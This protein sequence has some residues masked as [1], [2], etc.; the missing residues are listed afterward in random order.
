MK[1]AN[2]LLIITTLVLCALVAFSSCTG[3]GEETTA[4]PDP[5]ENTSA[6]APE[7]SAEES[8]DEATAAPEETAAETEATTEATHTHSFGAWTVVKAATCTEGGSEERVCSCGEKE[9]R[10]TEA[11]G[12]K[13]GEWITDLAA[14]C[15]ETGSMHQACSV[16]GEALRTD[17]LPALGHKD[18]EWIVDKEATAD[19]DG[20]RHQVCSECGVTLKTEV[21]ASKPHT[22]GKWI[23]DKDSTCTE[24]GER[25]QVCS[26]CGATLKT[27]SI[28]TKD[29]TEVKDAAVA[30]TC[31]KEGLTEGKHCSVCKFVIKA[32]EKIKATGHKDG[33]WI[34]DKEPTVDAEGSRHLAC[35]NCGETI[36]EEKLAKLEPGKADYTV[37]VVD[38]YGAP[39]KD[40]VVSFMQ[41]NSEAAK[42]ST[43]SLGNANATLALGEYSIVLESSDAYYLPEKTYKVTEAV[44]SIRIEVIR[45][46][47]ELEMAY[48]DEVNG[49]HVV[50]VGSVRVPVAK[51]EMRYFFFSPT[52]GGMYRVY[53]DSDKVE[54]GYYGASYFVSE[55]NM[56]SIVENGVLELK[57]LHSQ[58]GN[59]MVIGL[60]S[61]SSAAT[62]C[63]L[64]IVKHSDIEVQLVELPWEQ[65]KPAKTPEKFVAPEGNLT[66]VQITVTLPA[67][68]AVS[69]IP[70]VYN[71]TDG[72]YHL[73]SAE[74]PV[75]YVKLNVNTIFQDSLQT[76]ANVSN[77]GRY[78]YDDQGNFLKKE[79]YNDAILAYC[80]AADDKYGIIPL[81]ADLIYILKSA[82]EGGWYDMTS[83]NSIFKDDNVVVMP[84]NGWLFACCYYN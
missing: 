29:H 76:I 5:S 30:A 39:A 70:V 1:K 53:T 84:F 20:S 83:P 40:I 46:S 71:E 54:V 64:T 52:E 57:V 32:Q 16:C 3:T 62:E 18:G 8:T 66:P 75:L 67:G 26:E 80:A 28:P 56:G 81:D 65:Y 77:I 60:R 27:E 45:Y 2:L 82:G 14:T 35:A 61:D 68:G 78:L 12:H 73:N 49:V 55:S 41:G 6:E 13:D 7:T 22:P 63:T 74:G 69:E 34:V 44:R 23:V 43:D 42:V 37:C 15:T 48:P 51:D 9:T 21:I 72:Y 4:D 79:S 50:S 47:N 38:G 19:A 10:N 58:V 17:T 31:T 33:E 11:V 36:R 25:H 24:E 59:K